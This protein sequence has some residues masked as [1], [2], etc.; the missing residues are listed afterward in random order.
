ML[1]GDLVG[2]LGGGE[3]GDDDADD[4]HGN[5]HPNRDHDAQTR[6]IPT[7]VL[8]LIGGARA[9]YSRQGFVP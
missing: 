4:G 8:A 7:R 1:H 9:T 3:H 6:A 2:V 5:D